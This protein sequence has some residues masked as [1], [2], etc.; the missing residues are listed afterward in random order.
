MDRILNIVLCCS[1]GM[2]TSLVVEKMKDSAKEKGVEAN[3]K[4]I[5]IANVEELAG[6]ED[7]DILLLGPQVRFKI[8]EF[9]KEFSGKDTV[10]D[11]ID[12]LDYGMLNGSKIL[13]DA[14]N[15]ISK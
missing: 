2:S 12:M 1:A 6:E 5:P 4:A 3:I 13:D 9:R 11:V 14:I 7:I 15:S 10:V 8:D